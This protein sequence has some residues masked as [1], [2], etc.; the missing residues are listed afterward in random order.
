M[1]KVTAL[2]L[3]LLLTSNSYADEC[4]DCVERKKS[5]CA[6]ECELVD[7]SQALKC[8]KDCNFQYCSHKCSPDHD[9]F[10][11]FLAADCEKCQDEQY[12]LCDCPTGSD[13]SQAICRISC[14]SKNCEKICK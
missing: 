5:M 9:V 12:Q 6:S 8:Q 11:N 3:F 2:F 7:S 13:R 14:A 1:K 4:I 10:K